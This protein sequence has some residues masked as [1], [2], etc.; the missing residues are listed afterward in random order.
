MPLREIRKRYTKSDMAIMA[1]RGSEVSYNM[2]RNRE[3]SASRR[4]PANVSE[5]IRNAPTG[6]QEGWDYDLPEPEFKA[7]EEKL[8]PFVVKLVN[9]EGRVDLRKV[10]GEEAMRYMAAMGIP[11]GRM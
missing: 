5:G 3:V 9:E 7:L 4:L 10:T 11:M 6:R 1:W 2:Q 8:S